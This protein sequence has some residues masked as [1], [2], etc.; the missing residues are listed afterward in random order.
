VFERSAAGKEIS[1]SRATY[2]PGDVRPVGTPE[3]RN[4]EAI[5]G[6]DARAEKLAAIEKRIQ[7]GVYNSRQ[8][9]ERVVDRLLDKWNLGYGRTAR[10]AGD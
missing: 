4:A 6:P 10:R 1:S 2:G 7:E 8:S 9:I 5:M 3:A